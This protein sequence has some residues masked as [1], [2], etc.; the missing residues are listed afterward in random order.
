[1]CYLSLCPAVE[2]RGFI[3]RVRRKAAT[4]RSD[5]VRSG[6][7]KCM[8]VAEV[9]RAARVT[10]MGRDVTIKL[11]SRTAVCVQCRVT[12]VDSGGLGVGRGEWRVCQFSV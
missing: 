2:R 9:V 3:S 1:M 6:K 7:C 4:A 10:R 11:R 12:R 8:Q 5:V